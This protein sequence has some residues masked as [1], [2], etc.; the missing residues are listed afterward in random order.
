MNIYDVL[1]KLIDQGSWGSQQAQTDAHDTVSAAQSGYPDLESARARLAAAAQ[2]QAINEATLAARQD[3]TPAPGQETP[4]AEAPPS[5]D[6]QPVP[7][8]S[9]ADAAPAPEP[10]PETTADAAPEETPE[11]A[12]EEAPPAEILST[13]HGDLRW[14]GDHYE[15]A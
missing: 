1:H 8:A 9:P 6:S 11:A 13:P 2:S 10:A 12:P 3:S 5:V 7:E 14:A 15:P 4:T